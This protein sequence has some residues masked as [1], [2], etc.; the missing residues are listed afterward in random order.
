MIKTNY[1][2]SLKPEG[3]Y[4]VITGKVTECVAPSGVE[5][6]SVPMDIR[7]DVPGQKYGGGKIYHA[8]WKN[9]DPSALDLEVNGYYFFRI[10]DLC[11]SSGIPAVTNFES[12]SD[13]LAQISF[14]PM[15][16]KLEHKTSAKTG[17]TYE[18]IAR[19]EVTQ[20]PVAVQALPE[21]AAPEPEEDDGNLPF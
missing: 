1:S 17:K 4:E 6:I 9:S 21:A 13:I 18:R 10:M 8:I 12:L 14:K 16:I 5:Y 3:D 19:I 7:K 11:K 20:Y 15:R 2:G